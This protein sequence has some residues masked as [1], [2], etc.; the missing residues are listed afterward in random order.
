MQLE[1][2]KAALDSGNTDVARQI[3]ETVL[4]GSPGDAQARTLLAQIVAQKDVLEAEALVDGLETGHSL[5]ES[6]QALSRLAHIS[7]NG[8]SMPDEEGRDE[9]LEAATA[10][11]K[12]DW[13]QALQHFISVIQKNR[14]YDDDGSRKA[15]IAIFSLLG[16][17][18]E[19]TRKHRRM[20]DMVLY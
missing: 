1:S 8:Q 16:P 4:A 5:R 20:F 9:Y 14:Y 10:V 7:S 6:I 13:D 11:E 17:T 12:A 18:H 3:L 2:A 19:L 15:C